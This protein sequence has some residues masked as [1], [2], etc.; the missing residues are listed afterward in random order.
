MK[1]TK[2]YLNVNCTFGNKY[3]FVSYLDVFKEESI[4]ETMIVPNL[5]HFNAN[6]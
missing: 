1:S 5:F 2:Q 4:S 3:Q 6:L